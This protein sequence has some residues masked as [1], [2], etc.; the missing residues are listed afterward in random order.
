MAIAGTPTHKPGRSACSNEGSCGVPT[1]AGTT[2]NQ[3]LAAERTRKRSLT[4][5]AGRVWRA[6]RQP[7]AHARRPRAHARGH[8]RG[9]PSVLQ[10]GRTTFLVCCICC[11]PR[12]GRYCCQSAIDSGQGNAIRIAIKINQASL[13]LIGW[14]VGGEL[15]EGRERK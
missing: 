9:W 3:A 7:A 8:T 13:P 14:L 6:P 12:W 10:G 15:G 4:R 11:C 1:T 5:G 2:Q